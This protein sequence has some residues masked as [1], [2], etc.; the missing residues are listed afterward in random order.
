MKTAV[1]IRFAP[2]IFVF[3]ITR[4]HKIAFHT[5][6]FVCKQIKSAG[7]CFSIY[8]YV[9]DKQTGIETRDQCGYE[10]MSHSERKLYTFGSLGLKS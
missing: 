10:K 5:L 9:S 6:I 4:I 7:V 1:L 3:T 2:K 8:I